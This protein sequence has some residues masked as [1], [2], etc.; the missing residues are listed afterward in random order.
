ML[1]IKGILE[2]ERRAVLHGKECLAPAAVAE[3]SHDVCEE[4]SSGTIGKGERHADACTHPRVTPSNAKKPWKAH[5]G[6]PMKVS[7]VKYC[8]HPPTISSNVLGG[9][10]RRRHGVSQCARD[11][12]FGE[13]LLPEHQVLPQSLCSAHLPRC[14]LEHQMWQSRQSYAL[15]EHMKV[16]VLEF[17]RHTALFLMLLRILPQNKV[18]VDDHPACAISWITMRH[19]L[20]RL[21]KKF[22][23][24]GL[25]Q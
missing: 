12:I 15:V 10:A 22:S 19:R 2:S 13:W 17:V 6:T 20:L 14:L 8:S 23:W 21:T 16:D 18:S 5:M 7:T 4:H 25:T 11:H 1:Q 9:T 24:K 3:A